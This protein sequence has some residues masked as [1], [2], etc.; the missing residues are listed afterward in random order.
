[1]LKQK[2]ILLIVIMMGVALIIGA[3]AIYVIYQGGRD[4]ERLRLQDIVQSHARFLETTARFN[5]TYTAYPDG[6]EAASLLQFVESQRGF[7]WRGLGASGEIALARR[8]GDTIVYLFRQRGGRI[9][10][11]LSVPM[12]SMLAEPMRAALAG[13]SGAMIGKDYAGKAVLAAYAP[14]AALNLGLVAKIDLDEIRGRFTDAVIP[15]FLIGAATVVGAS[16]LFLRIT[17]PMVRQ[18]GDSGHASAA[19]SNT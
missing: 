2:R 16:T 10:Q 19:C 3:S 17:E 12:N 11:P 6:P 13:Q 9:D 8:E 4:R 1:M 14:V 15:L 7:A 5:E 18:L